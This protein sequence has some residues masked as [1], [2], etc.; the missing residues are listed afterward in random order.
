MFWIQHFTLDSIDEGKYRDLAL[1]L[2]QME[3]D[4]NAKMAAIESMED[5]G[6]SLKDFDKVSLC[7][8]Y[9]REIQLLNLLGVQSSIQRD[10]CRNKQ[11]K[12]ER[13]YL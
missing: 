13:R 10:V 3:N 1:Q 11:Y 9:S 4:Y 12:K 5:T 2:N 6:I 7:L 8:I